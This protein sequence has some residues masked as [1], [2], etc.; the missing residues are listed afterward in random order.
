[1]GYGMGYGICYWCNG[2][3]VVGRAA[4]TRGSDWLG[5]E[6]RALLLQGGRGI[7]IFVSIVRTTFEEQQQQ[8][9]KKMSMVLLISTSK[10]CVQ[11]KHWISFYLRWLC[12]VH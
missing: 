10:R 2:L 5:I 7:E 11:K 1:M 8:K 9:N 4:V 3:V 6:K 12:T